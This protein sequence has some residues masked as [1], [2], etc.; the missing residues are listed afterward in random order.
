VHLREE[1]KK[2]K[3]CKGK[4]KIAYFAEDKNIF[5][6]NLIYTPFISNYK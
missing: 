3:N 4:A 1:I 5:A 2:N 6:L